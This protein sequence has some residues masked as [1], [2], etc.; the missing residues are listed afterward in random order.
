MQTEARMLDARGR[1]S[2]LVVMATLPLT[3]ETLFAVAFGHVVGQP[4]PTI[5][6][7]HVV[8]YFSKE[9][10]SANNYNLACIL[11]LPQV[12]PLS[13]HKTQEHQDNN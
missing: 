3:P 12:P 10:E 8:G 1:M 5:Q 4:N 11:T 2:C 6:G 7:Y 13:R 9:K